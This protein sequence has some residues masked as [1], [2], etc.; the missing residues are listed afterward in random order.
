MKT[1]QLNNRPKSKNNPHGKPNVIKTDWPAY[2]KR[3]NAEGLDR[4][5]KM[6]LVADK[7]RELLGIEKGKSDRRVSAILISI[8]KSENKCSYWDLIRHF[9]KYP[10][11]LEVCEL[12]RKYCRAWYQL[13][14]SEIDPVIL[15]KIVAWMGEDDAYGTLMTDTSGFSVSAYKEWFNAKY[16]DL[17]VKVF[18]KMSILQSLRGKICAVEIIDGNANDFPSLRRLLSFLPP[19]TGAEVLADSAYSNKLNCAAVAKTGRTPIIPPGISN[20]STQQQPIYDPVVYDYLKETISEMGKKT[21]TRTV[22]N[23]TMSVTT[24]VAQGSNDSRYKVKVITNM[25]G[26][27]IGR[28]FFKIVNMTDGTYNLVNKNLGIKEIFTNILQG[29]T[30]S[31]SGNSN[32]NGARIDLHDREYG[33]L[34]IHLYD[35]YG[36][37]ANNDLVNSGEMEV[38]VRPNTIDVTWNAAPFYLHWCIVP[39][40]FDNGKAQYG[41]TTITF[42]SQ[43]ERRSSHAFTNY[44]VGTTWYSVEVNFVY[45]SW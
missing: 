43:S 38:I 23:Q 17:D 39:H 31:G 36:D 14:I 1:K 44:A 40:Q 20:A 21:E 33:T 9:N 42:D 37:C 8:L 16:G 28:E 10:N 5:K 18:D 11:D 45:C 15:Q 32:F 41:S 7:A 22:D 30:G 2:N 12:K 27:E 29:V 35:N 26:E 4:N 24:I 6:A 19:G 25:N 34:N 3:R 13:R